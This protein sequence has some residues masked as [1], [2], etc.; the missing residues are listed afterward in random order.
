MAQHKTTL[1]QKIHKDALRIVERYKKCEVEL[2]EIFEK[3]DRH[4][5]HYHKGYG[6]LFKYAN[7][8]ERP[9]FV[10]LE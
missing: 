1:I 6:S 10:T 3:A 4:K 2:I 7:S 8:R 5:I 9:Y